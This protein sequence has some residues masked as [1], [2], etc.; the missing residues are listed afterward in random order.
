[1]E[2]NPIS[3]RIVADLLAARTG[4]FLGPGRMWRITSALSGLFREHDIENV[5]QL[6]CLLAAPGSEALAQQVVEALLNNE[7]YFFRD[8]QMFD[9]IGETVLPEL[10]Q[11]RAKERRLKIWSAGCSSGQELLSVAMVILSQRHR[12][13]G[14]QIELLGTDIS[15]RII[16]AANAARYTQFE[17][18]RGLGVAQMLSYFADTN[19]GWQAQEEVSRMV[20]FKV[21]NLL[22]PPPPEGPFD[23][24]L[25]RN[26]LLYFDPANRARAFERLSQGVAADGF[27]MLGAGETVVGQTDLF[28]P[29]TNLGGFYLPVARPASA[30]PVAAAADAKRATG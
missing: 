2:M 10:A 11:R 8:K 29:R 27:L 14:W 18:Q 25:C 13:E 4:Q 19:D 22:D 9:Q 26:V 24:V 23:L 12:F 28:E 16:A 1:M 3:H 20:H 7:T 30:R 5:D 6:V 15:E 21:R 17:V